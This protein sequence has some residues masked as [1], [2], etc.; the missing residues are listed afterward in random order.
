VKPGFGIRGTIQRSYRNGRGERVWLVAWAS[1]YAPGPP[2][3][4]SDREFETGQAVTINADGELVR[5]R[6][7]P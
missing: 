4:V 6:P 1:A 5:L 3:V 2:A 7:K